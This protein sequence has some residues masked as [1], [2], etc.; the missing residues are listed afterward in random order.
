MA[1]CRDQREGRGEAGRGDTRTGCGQV[2]AV[3]N[4][5]SISPGPCMGPWRLSDLVTVTV[6][7]TTGAVPLALPCAAACGRVRPAGT[8]LEGEAGEMRS[9]QGEEPAPEMEPH[10]PRARGSAAGRL[11]DGPE[12][13]PRLSSPQ[14]DFVFAGPRN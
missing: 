10:R 4:G 9:S 1:G 2:P 8:E 6:L 5:G 11:R 14:A 12:R 3:G 13:W 7:T